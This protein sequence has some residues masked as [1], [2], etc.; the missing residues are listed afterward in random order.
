M[1]QIAAAS[2]LA[3]VASG[4][5]AEPMVLNAPDGVALAGYD[6]VAYFTQ[7]AALRGEVEHGV[8]WRGAMWYFV[9]DENLERFEMDPQ[10]FVPQY[11]GFCAFSAAQGL[12]VAGDPT[13]FAVH[14]GKLYLVNSPGNLALWQK[15]IDAYVAKADALWPGIASR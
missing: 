8:K 3:A 1:K 7:N 2:I 5:L 11:G 14:G 12:K 9:S 13:A 4:A 15:G 6:A 10:S